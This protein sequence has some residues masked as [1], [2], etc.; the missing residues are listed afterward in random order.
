MPY[1]RLFYHFVWTTK[2]RAPLITPEIEPIIY[3][4]LRT[5]AIGLDGT[6]FAIGGIEDHVH[7][8]ASV[9]PKIAVATFVGQIKGVTSTRFNKEHLDKPRFY[10]QDEYGAFSFDGKRLANV[11]AYVER[12]K[13]HHA[14]QNVIPVLE[15][16]EDNKIPPVVRE[17]Q[18][19]YAP[20][21]DAW[22]QE[23]L[24]LESES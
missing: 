4:Y 13:E 23:M 14:R 7:I 20:N 19:F 1:Y 2:L 16:V 12:Q 10:W 11:I 17:A 9:P 22:W 5:K 24:S 3:N 18:A 15:R 6:V 21:D 8:V